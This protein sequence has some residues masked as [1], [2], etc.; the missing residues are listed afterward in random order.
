MIIFKCSFLHQQVEFGADQY[1]LTTEQISDQILAQ[2]SVMMS[3]SRSLFKDQRYSTF[4][5]C[6]RNR[7]IWLFS[8]QLSHKQG[9]REGYLCCPELT[10]F[11]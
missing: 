10:S 4:Q 8:R 2:L 3:Q 6:L 11:H 9:Y 5:K 1:Q 7:L